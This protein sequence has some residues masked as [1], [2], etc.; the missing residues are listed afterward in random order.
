MSLSAGYRPCNS[1][2]KVIRCF[3]VHRREI[4]LF[5]LS[6]AS[7]YW[8]SNEQLIWDLTGKHAWLSGVLVKDFFNYFLLLHIN[9]L[10]LHVITNHLTT[11]VCNFSRGV[12]RKHILKNIRREYTL[13]KTWSYRTATPLKRDFDTQTDCSK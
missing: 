3:F 4:P 10:L 9:F 1:W 8:Y 7:A 2:F 6:D 11:K 13:S 5:D 12:L